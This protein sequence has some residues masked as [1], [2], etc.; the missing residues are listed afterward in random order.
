MESLELLEKKIDELL[1]NETKES[2]TI[3]LIRVR[4]KRVLFDF[5]KEKKDCIIDYPHLWSLK[6]F[7]EINKIIS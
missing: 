7:K 5:F 2:L 4:I 3:Y 6:L 1:E